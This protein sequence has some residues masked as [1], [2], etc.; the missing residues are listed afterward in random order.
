MYTNIERH[1][2]VR[3]IVPLVVDLHSTCEDA[4]ADSDEIGPAVRSL[5]L[6]VDRLVEIYRTKS[7]SRSAASV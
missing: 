4:V 7:L 5:A 1:M 6:N 2:V 3:H